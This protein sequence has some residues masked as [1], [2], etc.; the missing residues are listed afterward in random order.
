MENRYTIIGKNCQRI[1]ARTSSPYQAKEKAKSFSANGVPVYIQ[2]SLG[3]N[4]ELYINGKSTRERRAEKLALI[5]LVELPRLPKI[6]ENRPF[7]IRRN[8]GAA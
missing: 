4:V 5:P 7:V 1:L 8:K 3:V 2:N 6:E